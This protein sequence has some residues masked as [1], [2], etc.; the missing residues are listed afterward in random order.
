MLIRYHD[1]V[2]S[3]AA[4]SLL[5]VLAEIPF[6]IGTVFPCLGCL[7]QKRMWTLLCCDLNLYNASRPMNQA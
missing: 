7:M 6:R 1:S 2:D 5:S 4:R 3:A